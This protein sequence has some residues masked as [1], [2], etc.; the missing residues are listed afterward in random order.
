MELPVGAIAADIPSGGKMRFW[1]GAAMLFTALQP[2]F[3]LAAGACE[4]EAF[5]AVVS[6]A[7]AALAAMND[8]NRKTFQAKLAALKA[9]EGWSDG[10][11]AAR[12]T[13]FVRDASITALDDSNKLALNK[14]SQLGGANLDTAGVTGATLPSQRCAMLEELRTLMARVVEN[15]RAKW[16]HM[17][18]K[19]DA[20]LEVSRQAK[21][22]AQ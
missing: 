6:E 3:A 2:S 5:A 14:V 4:Q 22:A 20:A 13:P 7:S 11:Y 12:A 15:T 17:L 10:E 18:G 9:R 1:L 19:L 8:G 16:A 21:A